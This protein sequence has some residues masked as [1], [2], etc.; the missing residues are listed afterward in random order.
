MRQAMNSCRKSCLGCRQAV[1]ER[2]RMLG[3]GVKVV[4]K[5]APGARILDDIEHLQRALNQ[6]RG[7]DL[8][9]RGI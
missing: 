9:P 2:A 5:R 7:H 1:V 4:S 6:L 3:S 8:V